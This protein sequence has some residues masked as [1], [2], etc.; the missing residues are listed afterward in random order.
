MVVK[1]G[2]DCLRRCAGWTP[3]FLFLG[4]KGET[5]GQGAVSGSDSDGVNDGG[6]ANGT[7][8]VMSRLTE[9]FEVEP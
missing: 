8:G 4:R 5:A 3:W 7:V 1:G 9:C 6:V 2:V